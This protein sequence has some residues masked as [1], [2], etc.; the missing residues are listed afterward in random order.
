MQRLIKKY[1][2]RVNERRHLKK[3]KKLIKIVTKLIGKKKANYSE[4]DRNLLLDI[5]FMYEDIVDY[6]LIE[7]YKNVKEYIACVD[8]YLDLE[9]TAY[10]HK[11]K[12]TYKVGAMFEITKYLLLCYNEYRQ[13]EIKKT[14]N[15]IR[16]VIK[17]LG[18]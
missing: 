18:G 7:N 8:A 13:D 4:Y 17:E 3:Q 10:E 16:D 12:V 6:L 11:V 14:L 15:G 9:S 2:E 5:T 1:N